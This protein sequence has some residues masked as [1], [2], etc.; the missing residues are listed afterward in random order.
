[1][2]SGFPSLTPRFEMVAQTRTSAGPASPPRQGTV[3]RSHLPNRFGSSSATGA[4]GPCGRVRDFCDLNSRWRAHGSLPRLQVRT[5]R[6][7]D[8]NGRNQS[9]R[10]LSLQDPSHSSRAVVDRVEVLWGD[11]LV[12]RRWALARTRRYSYRTYAVPYCRRLGKKLYRDRRGE[13]HC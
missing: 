1:M 7:W 13:R 6:E 3:A 2:I 8:I 9:M 11:R 10:E 5:L 12:L 4:E